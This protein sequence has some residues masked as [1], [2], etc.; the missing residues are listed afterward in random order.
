MIL[1]ILDTNWE[2]SQDLMKFTY[3]ETEWMLHLGLPSKY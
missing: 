2:K 1:C 3:S